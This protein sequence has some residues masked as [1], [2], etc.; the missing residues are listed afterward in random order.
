M[1]PFLPVSG[2]RASGIY[3]FIELFYFIFLMIPLFGGAGGDKWGG[4]DAITYQTL[5]QR[6]SHFGSGLRSLGLRPVRLW[7]Q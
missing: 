2:V 3:L 1:L 4:Y 7:P 5:S 6:V